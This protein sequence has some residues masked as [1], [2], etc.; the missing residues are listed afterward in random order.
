MSDVS[1]FLRPGDRV[2]VYWI[3]TGAESQGIT[4]LIH[5]NLQLIAVDQVTDKECHN[6]ILAQSVAVETTPDVVAKLAQEQATGR[7]ALAVVGVT[8][9]VASAEVS[10]DA[11]SVVGERAIAPV[12]E[13]KR[14]C[15][16]R[17][18]RGKEVFVIPCPCPE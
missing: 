3:G 12:A 7:L 18:R 9:D 14:T 15:S 2:D 5:A 1:G 4:R 16:I 17:E 13:A 6:P 10:A 11:S 8:D